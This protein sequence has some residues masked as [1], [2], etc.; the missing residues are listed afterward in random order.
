MVVLLL[1]ERLFPQDAVA[2]GQLEMLPGAQVGMETPRSRPRCQ[3]GRGQDLVGER[4]INTSA[5]KQQQQQQQEKVGGSLKAYGSAW[6]RDPGC[7]PSTVPRALML[8]AALITCST[9]SSWRSRE[10]KSG[11]GVVGATDGKLAGLNRSGGS[12]LV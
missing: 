7:E 12:E 8:N 6:R 4:I 1:L 5:G 11:V 2:A 10:D 3:R 9:W